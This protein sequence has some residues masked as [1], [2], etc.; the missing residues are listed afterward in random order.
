LEQLEAV[1]KSGWKPFL[2]V[3][4][5]LAQVRDKKLCRDKYGSFDEYW[6]K[7][8]GYSRPITFRIF[9]GF[10]W[11]LPSTTTMAKQLRHLPTVSFPYACI[12]HSCRMMN[13][14]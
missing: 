4:S 5:A 8:L 12:G 14:Q 7:E 13:G 6:R 3:G 11:V 9:P 2:E 1:I 10:Y